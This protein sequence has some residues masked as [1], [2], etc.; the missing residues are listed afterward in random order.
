[1]ETK[2]NRRQFLTAGAVV[3]GGAAVGSLGFVRS[4]AAQSGDSITQ[5]A[6]FSIDATRED[7]AI[8][9]LE[10]LVRGVEDNEPD[11]LAYIAYRE[12]ENP[13]AIT[14]IEVYKDAA[15]LQNHGQ[16]PHLAALRTAFQEGLFKPP[17]KI[18]RLDEIVG[19]HRG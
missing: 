18:V 17:V 9:A 8:A 19:V 11:V 6:H 3:A 13:E 7:E 14:F 12:A 2:S 15:A 16:Q 4:V 1:M 10:T 5:L